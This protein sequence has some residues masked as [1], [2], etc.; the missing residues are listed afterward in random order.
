MSARD[1]AS[2]QRA[3]LPAA[4]E[5]QESP[6]SP[7]GHWLLGILITLFT[8]GLLWACLGEVDIVVSAPGKIVPAGQ[9]KIVQAHESGR[10]A[11]I[12][13]GEGERVEAGQPLIR[14]D[15]TYADA[16][17]LS[18]HQQ[19]SDVGLHIS[20]RRELA[21][22][23][24][25]QSINRVLIAGPPLDLSKDEA[26]A[27]ALYLQHRT[28]I[29]AQLNSLGR[30]RDATREQQTMAVA[31]R[32]K[33]EATLAILR[34]RVAAHKAL[35]EKQYG[36][37]IHYLEL[38]QAQTELERSIPVLRAR[39][40]QFLETVAALESRIRAAMSEQRK[41]NLLELASLNTQ[42]SALEQELRK[43]SQRRRQL[44]LSAPVAGSVQQLVV[45]TVG[46]VVTPGQELMRI[47][48]EQV[49]VEV[50]ALLQNKDIGFVVEGQVAEIKVDTFNFTKYGLIAARVDD[51]S[52]D[53]VE[54]QRLGWVFKTRL[55]LQ[56]SQIAVEGKAVKLSP[57]MAVTAEIKTGKRRLIEFF[58]SPLLRYRQESVRER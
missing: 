23:L 8:L 47:V 26:R 22:W 14:L 15:P 19:L 57:G 32:L 7:I 55:L 21:Q 37:R 56:R 2:S 49:A 9:V 30:E 36:A 34:Q 38:L 50:E 42:R 10:V 17:G 1:I 12:L 24:G 53:A 39:E 25:Q 43:S 33:V 11:T 44:V 28:E 27:R 35:L 5:V 3:F 29:T 46:G 18:I 58:L 4:L 13:V 41:N 48:P 40:R 16:D 20:W 6:A 52:N 31:E 54:D 45:H 51:I